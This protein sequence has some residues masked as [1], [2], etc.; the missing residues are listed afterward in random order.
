MLGNHKL[1][2][3]WT[4]IFPTLLLCSLLLQLPFALFR[5]S[6]PPSVVQGIRIGLIESGVATEETIDE[7]MVKAE[8]Q[9]KESRSTSEKI[10]IYTRSVIWW[11][12][13][14]SGIALLLSKS[15]AYFLIYI[16]TLLNLYTSIP[17]LPCSNIF[18]R[19]ILVSFP[20]SQIFNI[21]MVVGLAIAHR[22]TKQNPQPSVSPYRS[23]ARSR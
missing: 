17:Y 1:M 23:P 7:E 19:W 13:L 15:W 4:I 21:L 6:I 9:Y 11:I 16:A 8:T 12:L 2:K 14:I 20:L 22:K 10:Q 18:S 3:H 5:V